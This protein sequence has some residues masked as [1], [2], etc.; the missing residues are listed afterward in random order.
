MRIGPPVGKGRQRVQG[1]AAFMR[2]FLVVL[3][4]VVGCQTSRAQEAIF[5]PG[6]KLK[7]ESAGGSGGEGPAWDPKLGVLTSGNGH[8]YRLDRSGKSSIYR[9]DA[10]TNGLLFDSKG[11]L[12]ACEPNN[13]L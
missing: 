8:I 11:R 10:G 4:V 12:L 13:G 9:K 5:A 3:S 1:R 2:C 7:V 6:A